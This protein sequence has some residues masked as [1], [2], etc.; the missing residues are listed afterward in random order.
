MIQI[1][2]TMTAEPLKNVSRTSEGYLVADAFCVRTG[3]QV[4]K[5]SELGRPDLEFVTAYRSPDEV[6]KKDSVATFAHK[7][8]TVGHP[9]ALVQKDN[10]AQLAVGEVSTEAL[11]DGERL[12]LQL[13]VKDQAAIDAVESGKARQ[14]SAGYLADLDW[15]PGVAPDGAKYDVRQV[16]IRVNHLALVPR[17]RAGNCQIGDSDWG[18]Q[19]LSDEEATKHKEV[20]VATKTIMLGD[21]AVEVIDAHAQTLLDHVA[22]LE[23]QLGVKDAELVE[24]KAK[25]MT[26]ADFSAA[27]DKRVK[28]MDSARA[29]APAVDLSKAVTDADIMRAVI[30]AAMPTL[31]LDGKSDGYVEGIFDTIPVA[32][33][34][35]NPGADPMRQALS[36]VKIGD[37]NVS[38]L[39]ID[40]ALEAEDK[41]W[42]KSV[43]NIN[44]GM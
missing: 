20:H 16:N 32:A 13:I 33:G 5:G 36:G 14:L 31:T 1:I 6:F 35:G 26:D 4:Y 43:S 38:N 30:T 37:L 10:W 2:D 25:I 8:I 24:T 7:P 11:R 3:T 19:P 34:G 39:T 22:N 17:G 23:R 42:Q 44:E 21:K 12:K 28:L 15:T 27:V 9:T 18:A 40:Q 41:S 29:K